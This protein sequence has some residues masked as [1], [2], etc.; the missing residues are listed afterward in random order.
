MR[1]RSVSTLLCC[2]T[3]SATAYAQFNVQDIK[4][5][6]DHP[7][8]SRFDGAK[9]VA[10]KVSE[11]DQAE[12][13]VGKPYFKN[14]QLLVDKLLKPEGKYTRIAYVFP[15]DR[16]G[17]EVFRNYQDAIA[18]AGMKFV[19]TCEKDACGDLRSYFNSSYL[20]RD[21]FLHSSTF[22]NAFGAGLYEPYYLVAEGARPDGSPVHV[23][24][25]VAPPV[26]NELGGISLQIVE[27]KPMETGKVVATLNA[28]DMARGIA[29]DG[30][31]AVYGVYFDTDKTA[32]KPE[33]RAALAEMA[34]LLQQ[35]KSLKVH[36]VG[37]TDNQGTP[38]HNMLLSQQRAASVV[39]AL[40]TEYKIDA[41][42][43]SAQGVGAFAPVATNDSEAGREKNRR[44]E[45]VKQ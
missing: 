35:D 6:K 15:K 38:A 41:G 27:G 43:L 33:S 25:A 29:A 40:V 45:L 1:F 10:Y 11:Y 30:K 2:V 22:H 36:I 32:V 20:L 37:H 26:R 39:K 34:K 18:K 4:G 23:A 16:T 3:V 5:G 8:L 21:G 9:M 44:V 31:V 42:R 12:L 7:L 19:Y 13:P 24:V 14:N 28:A 17:L